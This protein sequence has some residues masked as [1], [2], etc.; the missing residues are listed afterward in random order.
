MSSSSTQVF[1]PGTFY[2]HNTNSRGLPEASGT[3]LAWDATAT[4]TTAKPG[5]LPVAKLFFAFIDTLKQTVPRPYE[6]L[7]STDQ[8]LDDKITAT[9]S[10]II[11]TAPDYSYGSHNNEQTSLPGVEDLARAFCV[12]RSWFRIHE[13]GRKCLKVK[14]SE[15]KK[16]HYY[17]HDLEETTTDGLDPNPEETDL[18]AFEFDMQEDD[19]ETELVD[20]NSDLKEHAIED[21]S[22]N[23]E[24]NDEIE[25]LSDLLDNSHTRYSPDEAT[26]HLPPISGTELQSL[27]KYAERLSSVN[28]IQQ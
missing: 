18:V 15:A 23:N 25:E 2:H 26:P 12:V 19:E 4:N 21:G 5:T 14:T 9:F 27:V 3:S 16:V 22:N 24:S 20:F 8:N 1:S 11:Y 17:T 10:V 6:W 7:K 28:R 13:P